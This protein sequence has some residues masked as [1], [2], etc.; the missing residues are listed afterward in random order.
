MITKKNIPQNITSFC[1]L[2][3]MFL[4]ACKTD[5]GSST[6]AS[7]AAASSATLSVVVHGDGNVASTPGGIQCGATCQGTFANSTVITLRA[8]SG[9]SS[10]FTGWS[11]GC[12][13]IGDCRVTIANATLVRAHFTPINSAFEGFG[14]GVTGGQ[15]GTVHTVT[16]LADSGPGSLRDALGGSDRIIRF[17]LA[18]TITLQSTISIIGTNITIDGFSAPSPGI[19]LTGARGL[20]IAGSSSWPSARGSNII[21]QGLRFRNIQ[22]DGIRIAFNAHDIVVDHNSFAGSTDGEVDITEGA[23]NVTVSYNMLSNNKGA[24]ASLLSYDAGSVSYHHNIFY[25]AQDRNPIVTA[26]TTRGYSTGPAHSDPV[27]DVRYNIIWKYGVGT[28]IMSAQNSVSTANVVSNLYWADSTLNNPSNVIVRS[29]Y[30][31]TARG[32]A[33][34]TGN[35]SVHDSRGCAY[36]YNSGPC[37]S[38]PATNSMNNH[39][40]FGAPIITGPAPNNQQGRLDEWS[41]VKAQ[42][43][44]IT[45]FPDDANDAAVRSAITIPAIGMYT[46]LWNIE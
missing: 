6:P 4:S 9:S 7:P 46:N 14:N 10:S 34:I 32:D 35:V 13:G 23:R 44:V 18:G 19:T 37:Y 11:E 21:I 24:G 43:G 17:A 40:E 26:T 15:N 5:S 25:G 3:L 22:D 36:A 1:L 8:T 30:D 29:S 33:Y 16:T 39:V 45:L 38:F 12:A 31:A 28:Y 42:A 20:E 41:K 2:A 27:A